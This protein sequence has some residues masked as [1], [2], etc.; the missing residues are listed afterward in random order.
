MANTVRIWPRALSILPSRA[1][2]PV[3]AAAHRATDCSRSVDAEG[4]AREEDHHSLLSGRVCSH[5]S[6]SARLRGLRAVHLSR[7]E[8]DAAGRGQCLRDGPVGGGHRGPSVHA[9]LH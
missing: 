4:C 6:L 7:E 3:P 5:H 8:A 1:L 2:S 9:A